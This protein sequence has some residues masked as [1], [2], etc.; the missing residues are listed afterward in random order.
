MKKSGLFLGLLAIVAVVVAV[1]SFE[2]AEKKEKV[3]V[4]DKTKV[5]F[6]YVGPVA[7]AGWTYEHDRGRLAVE[8]EHGDKVRD[9]I[10]RE[11]FRGS[12]RRAGNRSDG[13]GRCEHDLHN[14]L[15]I[16]E[17]DD[18]SHA[19]QFPNVKFEHA[20]GYKRAD[21][22]ATYSSRVFMRAVMSSGLDS[23]K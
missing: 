9:G 7:D 20:T 4:A 23:R 3:V 22:V 6:V 21:N 19:E 10:C 16:H 15:R 1:V 8:K 14:L 11:R 13:G 5:G 12:R 17:S 2:P 18:Q